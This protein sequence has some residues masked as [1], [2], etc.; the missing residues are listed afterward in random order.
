MKMMDCSEQLFLGMPAWFLM[1][2]VVILVLW[3]IHSFIVF[4]ENVHS[5]YAE[6]RVEYLDIRVHFLERRL[7]AA[8]MINE[9]LLILLMEKG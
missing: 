2:V 9:T 1:L 8:N 4:K 6:K 7:A 5:K 3:L